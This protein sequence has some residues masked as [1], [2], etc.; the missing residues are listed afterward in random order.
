M[1]KRPES[2][3]EKSRLERLTERVL[4]PFSP[5]VK[6]VI[7][8]SAEE[9]EQIKEKRAARK[10]EKQELHA[11]KIEKKSQ[12]K[13]EK[14]EAK[15]QKKAEKEEV[16]AQKK[17]V[18]IQK[19]AEKLDKKPKIEE[20]F[21][22][23][24]SEVESTVEP[25]AAEAEA[26]VQKKAEPASVTDLPEFFG[27]HLSE[28]EAFEQRELHRI[29]EA[30]EAKI[31]VKGKGKTFLEK[32][33]AVVMW[34][35]FFVRKL[36]RFSPFPEQWRKRM[37]AEGFFLGTSL[38]FSDIK[39]NRRKKK[40]KKKNSPSNKDPLSAGDEPLEL[41]SFRSP[42]VAIVNTPL[43]PL[44][45]Y[46]TWVML[47]LIA[48]MLLAMTLLP[49][50]KV[51]SIKGRLISKRPMMVIQASDDGIVLD[52]K[53]KVGDLIKKGQEIGVMDPRLSEADLHALE[54]ELRIYQA[55]VERLKAEVADRPYVPDETSPESL[56]EAK[57][58]L[59]RQKDMHAQLEVLDDQIESSQSSLQGAEASA[60]MYGSK[61]RIA[62]ELLRI[63]QAEQHH[64]VGTRLGTLQA[65]DTVMDTE[66]QLID[67]QKS[68]NSAKAE[69]KAAQA[70]RESYLQ[71]WKADAYDL[72]AQT[73]IKLGTSKVG[74]EKANVKQELVHLR[75]P[76]DG[77]VIS[78]GRISRGAVLTAG[79]PFMTLVPVKGG[80]EVEGSLSPEDSGYLKTGSHAIIKF[81][82]FP[83]ETYGGAEGTVATI[84]ADSFIPDQAVSENVQEA[85]M[86][87][88]GK[89]GV[90]FRVKIGIDR[91]NLHGTPS[92]F[93]PAAGQAV[94]AEVDVGKRTMMQYLFGKVKANLSEG[95]REPN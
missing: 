20:V 60:A 40:E 32:V 53:A 12:K 39:E 58:Y 84:S 35:V 70:K 16:K 21:T 88:G 4:K 89:A 91:Y 22:A 57:N 37:K 56:E 11:A 1:A 54:H 41:L 63:R 86:P 28:E 3:W 50:N 59:H 95:M 85:V 92:F 79:T 93:H 75:A 62:L 31:H 19:K 36:G 72:L 48:S 67:A 76:E 94:T 6:L 69:L 81:L 82:T 10:A 49:I 77:I 52:I 55:Q 66:R 34:P 38:Y 90:F 80:V 44:A 25:L 30:L 65:Q 68:A 73:E 9:I 47:G 24:P 45:R 87:P 51:V 17:E 15:A 29:D 2:H 26:F 83:Y 74:Y 42:T 5:L 71:S 14:Q 78:Q 7:G 27:P 33:V 61:L 13:V 18:K 64:E 8:T 43:P 23:V 46:I